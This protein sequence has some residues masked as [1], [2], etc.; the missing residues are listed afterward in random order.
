MAAI[1]RTYRRSLTRSS[2]LTACCTG[3]LAYWQPSGGEPRWCDRREVHVSI[4]DLGFR[5]GVTAV[6]RLRTYEGQPFAVADHLERFERTTFVLAIDPL[7]NNFDELIDELLRRN[8]S[9]I[10]GHEVGITLFA[11]PGR[12]G[13]GL[14][15]W[16]LHL[17]AIDQTA[18]DRRRRE[19]V[20]LIVTPIEQP[21]QACWPRELKVRSRLHYY[22]SRSVCPR[23]QCRRRRDRGVDR[24]GRQ[25]DRNEHLQ[26][27]DRCRRAG[28]QSAGR[29]GAPRGHAGAGQ[30]VVGVDGD[31]GGAT[32]GC[33]PAICVR[34]TRC[35]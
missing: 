16:A 4:D 27:R 7:P 35:G 9:V 14:P 12:I 32:P 25:R 23:V 11:T 33:F 1:G 34:P 2:P 17:N 31:S 26:P 8:R 21:A 5:Q 30:S 19:G 29:S 28:D 15:S 10:G 24:R 13:S 22:G 6:E 18:V 20:P 3:D